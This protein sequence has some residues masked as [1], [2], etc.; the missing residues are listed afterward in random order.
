MTANTTRDAD[1]RLV[2]AGWVKTLAPDEIFVFGSN[3]GGRHGGGAARI[4]HDK[5][6]AVWGQ[7]HGLQGQ[8][9]AVDTMTDA[10]NMASEIGTFLR[11]ADAHPE[12]TFLVTEL[13]CGIGPYQPSDVAPLL[14]G[15]GANVA[16]PPSFA[17]ELRKAGVPVPGASGADAA[18]S[19]SSA[20]GS[21]GP[22]GAA[23]ARPDG[24]VGAKHHGRQAPARLSAQQLDRA[25]GAMVGMAIGDALGSQYE[26]GPAHGDD[27]V[28]EFGVGVFGHGVGEWTDDTSMAMPILQ[29]LARGESLRDPAVLGWIAGEWDTWSRTA[30]D[31]GAQTRQVLRS[32]G[33]V[34]TEDVARAA[35]EAHHSRSG[36]SGGNGSLMRTGP[37]ALGYLAD[38][39]ERRLA[40]AAG[41]I[42]QLTH[43]EQ[44]NVDATVIWSLMIRHAVLTGELEL[45]G[46]TE[47]FGEG[48]PR[49]VRWAALVDEACGRHPRDFQADNGWVVKAFQAALAAVFGARDFTDAVYRAI[50]GGGDTDTVAAIAG[51]LAGARFGVSGIPEE[52]QEQVHG[53][54][55]LRGADLVEL[56]EQAAQHGAEDE[57]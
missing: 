51:A 10:A 27:F 33:G 25:A 47:L 29:A 32:M 45:D 23:S 8:S 52:W 28:P 19:V 57:L 54:P 36:R 50:R 21:G 30:K 3:S 6:G 24:L 55:G 14:A 43:W 41:R 37:V 13:G 38:G 5:F 42:A 9:Y 15:A 11:F 40:E 46:F 22:A 20:P 31:V 34:H 16:L 53:W 39:R 2:L 26:F 56:A 48:S 7:G 17:A 4:A 44:D 35:S 49:Q 12:L 18:A 1:G